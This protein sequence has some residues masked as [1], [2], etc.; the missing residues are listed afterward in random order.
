MTRPTDARA[1]RRH[2]LLKA[3]SELRCDAA[4][5]AHLPNVRYL[6]GFTGSNGILFLSPGSA[7]LFTDPRY[8]LQAHEECDCRVRIVRGST[9][10]GV[11]KHVAGRCRRLAMEADRVSHE[12]WQ[13]TARRLGRK[14]K[15]AASRG[16][17]EKLRQVKTTE[18]ADAIR[19]SARL[20]AE[21]FLE[22]A[23]Q[24]RP[25]M[26]ER[27]AAAELDYRMRRLGAEGPAFETIV[28]AGAR[29]ALPHARPGDAKLGRGPV[30]I[31]MGANV[32]GWMSDMTR[33]VHLGPPS[34]GFLRLFRA[35]RRA[36][37]AALAE[38]RAG[39]P[40]RKVDAAARR[41]LKAEGLA[42]YFTH[43]T[44][45]GVGL[46]IHEAP[47]LGAKSDDVLEA[48]MVVTL[49]PG[50]YLAG[51]AGVRIEDTVLVTESGAEILTPVGKDL[52]VL[53]S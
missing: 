43:S 3:L 41:V 9:W 31:D 52:L 10:E 36:Q 35:V 32:S 7:I 12:V 27:D 1:G 29:A 42:G 46:E 40:A 49:E 16:L 45:H 47:R 24:L 18:E 39:V 53:P 6:T 13:E 11:W 37:E 8:D 51:T 28:A 48:G 17:V 38:V 2:E 19:A 23:R 30:L 34:R 25:E 5:V 21:A 33:M 20:C 44:G 26:S 15:L 50:V 14:A 4:L 22:T